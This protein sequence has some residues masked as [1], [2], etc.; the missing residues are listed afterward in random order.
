MEAH[1]DKELAAIKAI[2]E[3]LSPLDSAQKQST[4]LYV[5]GRLNLSSLTAHEQKKTGQTTPLLLAREQDVV[6]VPRPAE[7]TDIRTLKEEKTP[8]SAVQMAVLVA[9]Y[10][11]RIVPPEERLEAIGTAEIDKYF[12]QAKYPLPKS[13]AVLLVDAKKAGYMES[14]QRGK[15]KLNPVGYNLAVHGMGAEKKDRRISGKK[16]N[17]KHK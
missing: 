3:A 5:L 2:L 10:L 1:P 12:D 16:N 4:M 13:S 7:V 11:S 6:P 14:T 17:K 9:Y 15:Y 8:T